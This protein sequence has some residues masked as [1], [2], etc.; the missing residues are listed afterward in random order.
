MTWGKKMLNLTFFLFS[1][2]YLYKKQLQR[3]GWLA[4][5]RE[6]SGGFDNCLQTFEELSCGKEI[7]FVLYVPRGE[8]DRKISSQYKERL[9]N[10]IRITLGL[11]KDEMGFLG[12]GVL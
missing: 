3:L 12:D 11:S 1:C 8:S 9:S 7:R 2:P 5:R 6:D 10:K 4:W